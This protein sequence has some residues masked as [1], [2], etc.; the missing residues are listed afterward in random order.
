VSRT[1]AEWADSRGL[2]RKDAEAKSLEMM[3]RFVSEASPADI[4]K[5]QAKLDVVREDKEVAS[6]SGIVINIGAPGN[7]IRLP[8]ID[9]SQVSPTRPAHAVTE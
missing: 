3:K 8:D 7:P 5:I 2:A 1:L 6:N 4:L 9:I